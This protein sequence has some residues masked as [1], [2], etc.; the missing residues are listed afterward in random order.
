MKT[1]IT[2]LLRDKGGRW[3][4]ASELVDALDVLARDHYTTRDTFRPAYWSGP[5]ATAVLQTAAGNAPRIRKDTRESLT[6]DGLLDKDG[7]LT[8]KGWA[9]VEYIKRT[10]R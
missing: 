9:A 5:K 3:T 6:E 7:L 10:Q 1:K 2:D 8:H 4:T